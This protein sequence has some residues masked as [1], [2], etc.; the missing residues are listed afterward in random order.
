MARPK[1][2]VKTIPKTT[3]P[4]KVDIWDIVKSINTRGT[5]YDDLDIEKYYDSWNINRC[6][7]NTPDSVLF[8]NEMNMSTS[9]GKKA[10]Y[11]FY[12]YGLEFNPKR[13]GPWN[14]AAKRDEYIKLIMERYQY[15][16]QKAR[17]V[18]PLL[19]DKMDVIKEYLE[20]GGSNGKS[21]PG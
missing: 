21:K 13:Y 16:Y 3:D 10:Q 9:L 1:K 12:Y 15:S 11:D 17:E 5:R 19:I 20:K 7:S 2:G 8:A 6:F 14:K 18:L 4:S